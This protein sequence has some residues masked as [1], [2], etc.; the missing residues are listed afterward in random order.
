MHAA[1][2]AA[3][4]SAAPA[5][6]AGG[7]GRQQQDR[8]VGGG[9]AVDVEPVER[10]ADGRAQGRVAGGGVGD[11]VG[12]EHDQHRGHR[13]GDHPGAL[14]E[15]ADG[16][17]RRGDVGLLRVVVGGEH[18]GGGGGARLGGGGQLRR[19]LLDPGEQRGAGQLLADDAR[20][21]DR[22]LDRAARQDLGGLLGRGVRGLEALG[23]GA[24]VGAA[25]VEDDGTQRAAGE[26]LLGPQHGRGL[27]LVGGEHP[28]G[29]PAGAVVDDEGEIEPSAVLD[30]SSDARGPEPRGR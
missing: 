21:A 6:D 14:G 17:A 11:G 22:D 1:W 3:V 24:R 26:D 7:A 27:H 10:D 25:G 23:P 8:V 20:G 15:P 18:R 5:C 13:G 19:R 12:G 4:S 29:G 9:A 30:P 28:G 16:E 2:T